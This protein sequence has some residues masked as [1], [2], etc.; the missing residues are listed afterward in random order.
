SWTDYPVGGSGA[1]V[2]ALVRGLKKHGG[3][4]RLGTHVEQ[5]SY[6]L[7]EGEKAVGV[8]LREKG[9]GGKGARGRR[10]RS[11]RARRAVVMNADRWA[12]AK[13]LPEGTIPEEKR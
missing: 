9:G 8:R 6:V 4:L 12:A 1:I 11:I 7:V 3:T 13:L 5:A 2:E 10:P